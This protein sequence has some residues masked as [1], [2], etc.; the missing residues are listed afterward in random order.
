MLRKRPG[1]GCRRRG[2]ILQSL[3]CVYTDGSTVLAG[4]YRGLLHDPPMAQ[5]RWLL[6]PAGFDIDSL[7]E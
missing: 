7:R 5:L 4:I 6:K 1:N 3:P 2:A